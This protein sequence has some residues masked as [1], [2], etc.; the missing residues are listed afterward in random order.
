MLTL[1][2]ILRLVFSRLGDD[3]CPL[4][5]LAILLTVLSRLGPGGRTIRTG[6]PP[7]GSGSSGSPGASTG[8]CAACLRTRG[9]PAPIFVSTLRPA[10][11]RAAC[12]R[13][14]AWLA[15]I[16]YMST[17][18]HVTCACTCACA[19]TCTYMHMYMC[20]YMFVHV[21][22]HA[23]VHVHVTCACTYMCMY[24]H[25]YMHMFVHVHAHVHMCM[26][27][28]VHVHVCPNAGAVLLW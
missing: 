5:L 28:H 9:V 23:H 14:G 17:H 3:D 4:M 15:H 19:C 6:E 7:R 12:V 26:C 27:A 18:V 22:A 1:L 8:W 10:G 11:R 24:M 13:C 16:R 20:M 25:V 2:K 21:H